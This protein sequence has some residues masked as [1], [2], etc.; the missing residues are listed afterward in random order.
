M[1]GEAGSHLHVQCRVIS[2]AESYFPA[3]KLDGAMDRNSIPMLKARSKQQ[4]TT[5]YPYSLQPW[6]VWGSQV[7]KHLTLHLK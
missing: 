2:S 7:S 4:L 3:V 1:I 5:S 6:S